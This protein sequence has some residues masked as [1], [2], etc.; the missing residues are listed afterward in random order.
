MDVLGRLNPSVGWAY[1]QV[2][3]ALANYHAEDV[4]AYYAMTPPNYR[5]HRAARARASRALAAMSLAL[6][7]GVAPIT[8]DAQSAAKMPRVG[9]LRPGSPPDPYVEAFR[10]GLNDLSC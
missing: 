6:A 10:R 7:L 1:G 9:L 4:D 2:K 5:S 3:L 8:G